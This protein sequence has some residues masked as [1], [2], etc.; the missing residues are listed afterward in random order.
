MDAPKRATHTVRA[1]EATIRADAI[2]AVS[3]EHYPAAHGYPIEERNE[4]V[5]WVG[6]TRHVIE[7]YR[8]MEDARRALENLTRRLGWAAP[9]APSGI[10]CKG[11]WSLGSACGHCS[12]C[13]AS[14][15][16]AARHL[17]SLAREYRSQRDDLKA[18][19][20]IRA[21]PDGEWCD[22]KVIAGDARAAILKKDQSNG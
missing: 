22:A 2:T 16:D 14:A 3:I 8:N 10:T 5:A 18:L 20:A 9:D 1:I 11:D 15:P 17:Q 13:L 4:I 12:R 7:T 19:D 21:L 6:A